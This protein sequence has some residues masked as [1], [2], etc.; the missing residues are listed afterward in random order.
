[1]LRRTQSTVAD[2][3][4]PPRAQ[5]CSVGTR[6]RQRPTPSGQLF[7]HTYQFVRTLTSCIDH[8]CDYTHHKS[9]PGEQG[10]KRRSIESIMRAPH[11]RAHAV[12]FAH[13]CGSVR[14]Q[15]LMRRGPPF[16]IVCTCLRAAATLCVPV[17]HFLALV[18][19]LL[20]GETV[21]VHPILA[22]STACRASVV[23]GQVRGCDARATVRL[24]GASVVIMP[25]TSK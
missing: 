4:G 5:S 16:A 9:A 14:G 12:A 17:L 11:V 21:S 6:M 24:V 8:A 3:D 13:A 2:A 18:Q 15:W 7:W 19:A 23:T 1:M 20:R 25:A 10:G 22:M